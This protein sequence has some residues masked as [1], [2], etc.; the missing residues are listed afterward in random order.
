VNNII[1]TPIVWTSQVFSGTSLFYSGGSRIYIQEDNIYGISY[2]LNVNG[3]DRSDKNVGTL[4]RKNGNTDITPM[5][6]ASFF[7]NYQNDSATNMMP[8]NYVS[9]LTGD[10][11]EL[12]A[13]RIGYAGTVYTVSN[14][15]WIKIQKKL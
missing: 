12:M 15:S 7:S 10:Y 14:G 8:E 1:A 5:S 11:I 2:V 3:T 4:I 13:F 9:L 6:S